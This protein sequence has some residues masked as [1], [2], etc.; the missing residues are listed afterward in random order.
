MLQCTDLTFLQLGTQIRLLGSICHGAIRETIAKFVGNTFP[1][2]IYPGY[3]NR[4]AAGTFEVTP[5]TPG[6]PVKGQSYCQSTTVHVLA[7][8]SV[9]S[10][11]YSCLM[12]LSVCYIKADMVMTACDK[13][14]VSCYVCCNRC[15]LVSIFYNIQL[16]S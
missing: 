12:F 14:S 5:S 4:L 10:L 2:P 3:A 7:N 16:D 9:S 8:K 1:G 15:G 11:A 13:H 6:F